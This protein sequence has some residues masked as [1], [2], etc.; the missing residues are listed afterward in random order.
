VEEFCRDLVQSSGVLLAPGGLF[1]DAGNHFRLGF[2][3]KSMPAALSKLEEFMDGWN[4]RHGP[5]GLWG[6]VG[7][8]YT[9]E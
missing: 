8:G 6:P 1:G 7:I 3:R 5:N 2:G 9:R 4:S